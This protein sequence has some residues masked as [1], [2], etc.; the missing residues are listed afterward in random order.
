MDT[1]FYFLYF[2]KSGN[3]DQRAKSHKPIRYQKRQFETPPVV[4]HLNPKYTFIR[5]ETLLYFE[6]F[7]SQSPILIYKVLISVSEAF[8]PM[9]LAPVRIKSSLSTPFSA[10]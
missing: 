5:F 6:Y 3:S 4:N 9:W 10:K 7:I 8:S 2:A 1:F